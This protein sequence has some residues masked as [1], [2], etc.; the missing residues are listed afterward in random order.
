M[1]QNKDTINTYRIVHQSGHPFTHSHKNSVWDRASCML[2]HTRTLTSHTIQLTVSCGKSD[3]TH[4]KQFEQA[5]GQGDHAE[6]PEWRLAA[7]SKPERL[8]REAQWHLAH[9]Y[10]SRSSEGIRTFFT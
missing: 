9:A 6:M 3:V 4:T 8:Q 1:L 7:P 2:I 10:T 5:E